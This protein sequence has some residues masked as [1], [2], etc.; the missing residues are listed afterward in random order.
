MLAIAL[1]LQSSVT[2]A[3]LITHERVET[4]HYRLRMVA[5]GISNV[6]VA[7]VALLSTAREL[8]G[9]RQPHFGHFEWVAN[10][11]LAPGATEATPGAL[12]LIQEVYCGREPPA[13]PE[14]AA[15]PDPNWQ[16]SEVQEQ[17]ILARTRAYFAAKDSGRYADAYAM[18]TPGMQAESDFTAWSRGVSDFNSRAGSAQGRR[19]IRVSWYNN[20]P[21]APVPGLY[22]AVDFNGDFANLHFLCGYVVWLLQTDGSWRLVREEQS[23][24]T[25]ADAPD[26]DA[27][28]IA[29]IRAQY[30]RD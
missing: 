27:A 20:P 1:L 30:C 2:P 19:L 18:L 6:E 10:E 9:A 17:Q 13:P 26:A 16:R 28:Q 29:Q 5:P 3:P 23:S 7:Q 22:A 12:A 25:R 24:A 21:Q 4:D 15:P 8:C 14:T 11:A